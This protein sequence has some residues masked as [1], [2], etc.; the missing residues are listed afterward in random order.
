MLNRVEP[1]LV[2]VIAVAL[3]ATAGAQTKPKPKPTPQ[4]L[5]RLSIE[6]LA[7]I[8]VTSVSR[9]SEQLS[10][11][12][13]AI[14]VVR[15]DDL[16][17]S[18]VFTLAEAMRLADGLD[19]ARSD[20]RTWA[21]SARGFTITSANKLLVLLD[22]RTV[23]SPLFSGTFW[24]V[25]DA[26]FADIDRIE[27]IRGPGGSMWGANAVNGVVNIIMKD[28]AQTRGNVALLAAGSD[29]LVIG[30]ARHGGAFGSDGSYR[31]YG[32]YRHRGPQLVASGAN[33]ADPID[34]GQ[35]GFRVES[36]RT[37]TAWFIQGDGYSGREGQFGRDDTEVAGGNLLGRW[38]RATR[39][40]GQF[41]LQAF[42]DR[43]YRNSPGQL[44]ESRDTVELDTQ[45]RVQ[46]G[47][48]D[49]MFGGA[50]RVTHGVDLGTPALF[51]SPER[52]TDGLFGVFVHDEIALKTNAYLIAGSKFERNNLT[53]LE[54]QPTLRFRWSP[55]ARH[56]VWAA[57]SRAVRLPTRLDTDVRVNTPV[58]LLEGN[59]RFR[60]EDVVAYEAGYRAVPAQ[61][62]SF[63]IATFVNRYDN[64]RSQEMPIAAGDPTI[65]A[66]SL[67]AIT[68][69]V[70][71]SS[72]VQVSNRCRVHGSYAY[73]H[74]DL[75]FD[76][77]SRDVTGG[78]AEGNDPS[79]RF[80]LRAHADP[81]QRLEVDG[82]LRYVGSRPAPDVPAYGELDLRVGFIISPSW[83]LSLIGQNL[84]HDHHPEFGAPVPT[85]VEF[86]RGAFVRS[87]WRF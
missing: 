58:L 37:D 84:L 28:A 27:V 3:P 26:L 21:I 13:A 20:S 63:D 14:S 54:V 60:S 44:D 10:E 9:R 62:I 85:R 35:G 80:S 15:G 43:T 66:N 42:Y 38:T 16:R 24:D 12:A 70:E 69:G 29:E 75:S 23:Y 82:I 78:R 45:Q 31:V 7:E 73:L 17:R 8:D 71:V 2:L 1:W 77:G 5:K 18:G 41:Q 83:E 19:V 49:L 67:N 48:H 40:R 25:Q 4:E 61:R 50:F 39:G 22:G 65:L 76:R 36:A 30:S 47:R 81:V 79:H 87:I 64:L 56:S 32:K 68:S 11:T 72:N 46:R 6:E 33:A 53:G 55:I 59:E 74:K 86:R 51:F 34:F 52:R 57:V